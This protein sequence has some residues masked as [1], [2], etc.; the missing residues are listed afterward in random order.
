MINQPR[1]PEHGTQARYIRGCQCTL[2][3]RAHATYQ[4][5]K[6]DEHHP[7]PT[8]DSELEALDVFLASRRAALGNSHDTDTAA[9]VDELDQIHAHIA[10]ITQVR[11][12]ARR[13]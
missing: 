3:A 11:D 9:R 12:A 6:Y 1:A 2:C 4:R 13:P 5:L 8:S 10:R 7:T